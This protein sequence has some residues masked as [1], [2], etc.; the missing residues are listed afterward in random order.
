MGQIFLII[1]LLLLALYCVFLAYLLVNTF[2]DSKKASAEPS[3]NAPPISIVI[4]FK[5][6]ASHLHSLL[7]SLMRQ[8][9][10]GQFEILLINDDST[11]DFEK[12]LAPYHAFAKRPVIIIQSRFDPAIRLTSKQQALDLGAA[13]A[14][15]PWLLFTDAD[16]EFADCWVA[17]MAGTAARGHDMVF[18][19]TAVKKNTGKWLD[20]M[21]S[22]QL[23]FLFAVAYAFQASK[24]AGSCMGNNLLVKK[25]AYA[26]V[27]GQK[28]VGYSIVEDCDLL[29]A[30]KRKGL[31]IAAAHP[32]VPAA[33]T[34]PC[35]SVREF[36]SQA[37]R[38]GRGGLRVQSGLFLPWTLFCFQNAVF[39]ASLMRLVP[40]Q[41]QLFSFANAAVTAVF[42]VCTFKKIHSREKLFLLPVF[43]LFLMI[44][45]LGFLAS[46]IAAPDVSW[47]GR[48][49]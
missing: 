13:R 21:Q 16:M 22:F 35:K 11:D 34:F 32:F 18:G 17:S 3:S 45:T 46:L 49:V 40:R 20:L 39:L 26:S 41:L 19:H 14:S 29:R 47:K 37:L 9:Y 44:E 7:N 1:S 23:E 25:E 31:S 6:E 42:V 33:F 30:F 2:F 36:I 4:P 24:I 15:H 12:V 8:D 48:K 27:G 43:Y 38:W 10:A 5:N 28:A